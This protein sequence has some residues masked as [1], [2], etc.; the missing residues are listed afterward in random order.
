MFVQLNYDGY[1]ITPMCSITIADLEYKQSDG[2]VFSS[3]K[4]FMSTG[5]I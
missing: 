1:D 5:Y 2:D 4:R 3:A